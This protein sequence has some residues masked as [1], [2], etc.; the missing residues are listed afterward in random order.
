LE[1]NPS[2]WA[3]A[4]N[5]AFI[6]SEAADTPQDFDKALEFAQKALNLRPDEPRILDTLAWIYYKMGNFTRA[7]GLLDR[8]LSKNP[9]EPMLN[10]HMAMV[11]YSLGQINEA[12]EIIEKTLQSGEAF[13][14]REK[15]EKLLDEMR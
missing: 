10:Y 5:I 9:D 15:A 3:A 11:L 1:A 12:R 7:L 8:A 4:N 6:L 13:E 14:G 2:L